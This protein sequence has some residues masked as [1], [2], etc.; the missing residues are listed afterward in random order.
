MADKADTRSAAPSSDDIAELSLE[1]IHL[2]PLSDFDYEGFARAVLA[3]WGAPHPVAPR[4]GE[5]IA[6]ECR[7]SGTSWS[8]C[9]VEHVRMVLANP[10]EWKGYEVRYLYAKQQPVAREPLTLEQ[11]EACFEEAAGA[12]E[13]THIR[14]A[15]AIERAHGITPP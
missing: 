5:P 13:S 12:D 10:E 3:R 2:E 7:F 8:E 11:I 15:R 9:D 14:F 6:G 4:D 1:F